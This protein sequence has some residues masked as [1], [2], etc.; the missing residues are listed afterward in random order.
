MNG[1]SN[2]TKRPKWLQFSNGMPVWIIRDWRHLGSIER[3]VVLAGFL[4]WTLDA[5]DFFLL[6]F[7]LRDVAHTFSVSVT[8]VTGAIL[9]TL[10][11]RPVGA[12][13]FGFLAD[14]FGRRP[15]LIAVVLFYSLFG[16][17]SAFAP[18][19][20]LFFL[21]RAF[22]GVAMGGEWGTGSALVMESVP[23]SCRGFVSGI[24]QAGYPAGYLLASLA[25]AFLYPVMGW[26]GLLMLGVLP[27]FLVLYIRRN[28][29]ESRSFGN[30]PKTPLNVRHLIR[31]NWKSGIFAVGLMT[32][33]NFLGHGT[34]D[35]YPTFLEIDHHLNPH[36]VGGIAV[37]YNI[38]AILGGLFM[39][40]LS[41]R[42][43]RRKAIFL[44]AMVALLVL[45]FWG[46]A[47]GVV[48]LAIAAF[49]MQFAVQGAWGVIP[50]YLNEISPAI[51]RG[52]FPGFVYQT[53]N[54]LAS[55][56]ATLQSSVSVYLGGKLNVAL[57]G[58]A[59]IS[60]LV[61]ALLIM[62][63]PERRGETLHCQ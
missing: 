26:R 2:R 22:F 28:V 44:A 24:L 17:L 59:G 47:R 32:A 40:S 11:T 30:K 51:I 33:F 25:F 60:A 27:A 5:F 12:L 63:G 15:I 21:L 23:P 29:P 1:A 20:G 45:P 55:A 43:G 41:E 53:G 6:V 61:I 48:W 7:V 31:D 4:G 42:I 8:M 9:L 37:L 52:T 54:L 38:G 13:L 46:W 16:F 62:A 56:N 49:F 19:L 36:E 34:Q 39:G 14:R 58:V 18:T 57:V 10:A 50:V 3:H 35:L